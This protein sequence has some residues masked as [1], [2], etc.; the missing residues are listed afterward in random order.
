MMN[1]PLPTTFECLPRNERLLEDAGLA[2]I[3]ALIGVCSPGVLRV[4]SL[5]GGPKR[6]PGCTPR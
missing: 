3:G 5:S 4:G 1:L 6:T 2:I